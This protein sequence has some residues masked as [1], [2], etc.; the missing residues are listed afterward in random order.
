MNV[1]AHCSGRISRAIE[2]LMML[3]DHHEL[4]QVEVSPAGQLSVAGHWMLANQ[5]PFL[6]RE[7]AWFIQD[8]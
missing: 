6:I 5:C 8:M 2:S 7:F 1:I 4:S 3:I